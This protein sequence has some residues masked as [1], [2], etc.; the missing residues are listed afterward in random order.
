M[1]F[2]LLDTNFGKLELV[3]VTGK[4]LRESIKNLKSLIKI[5]SRQMDVLDM[6]G[7]QYLA[8]VH[9]GVTQTLDDPI[10]EGKH[11][12]KYQENYWEL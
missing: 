9:V 1:S 6:Y 10:Q 12:A 4:M 3:H 11:S 7:C 5:S 8:D 2:T